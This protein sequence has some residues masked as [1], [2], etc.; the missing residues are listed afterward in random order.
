MPQFG[1]DWI[2]R[3]EDMESPSWFDGVGV[4]RWAI[5]MSSAEVVGN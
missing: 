4:G 2:G 1:G 3:G 5:K